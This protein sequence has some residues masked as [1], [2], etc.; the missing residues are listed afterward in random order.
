MRIAPLV[1]ALSLPVAACSSR[2]AGGTV[3]G[4]ALYAT[5]CATCHGEHG[6]PPPSMTAQL[7][8]R[9]LRSP[10]FRARVTKDLVAEQIRKGSANKLMPAF[11]G[12]LSEAQIAAIAAFV[13]D[14]LAR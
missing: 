8:A 13:T 4:E 6:T 14:R 3:D 9:D 7:G 10:E 2:V 12:A 5:A 1:L 11:A